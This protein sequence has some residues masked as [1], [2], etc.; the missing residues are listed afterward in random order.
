METIYTQSL[1]SLR[2]AGKRASAVLKGFEKLRKPLLTS[3][4]SLSIVR[5]VS[6]R[7]FR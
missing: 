4:P 6:G 2:D 1:H 7:M 5:I 3:F